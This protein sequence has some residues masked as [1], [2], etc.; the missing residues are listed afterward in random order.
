MIRKSTSNQLNE[1]I[2]QL[3]SYR[4]EQI[5]EVNLTKRNYH[6]LW[7]KNN[8]TDSFYIDDL[9]EGHKLPGNEIKLL[10]R[11]QNIDYVQTKLSEN[12]SICMRFKYKH[13]KKVDWMQIEVVPASDYSKHNVNVLMCIKNIEDSYGREYRARK[14]AEKLAKTDPLTGYLNRLAF[15]RFCS[16]C[17][18]DSAGVAFIDLNGLKQI[19][20]TEGHKAGDAYIKK[21]CNK[22]NA[23]FGEF[24]KYRIGG[25]EFVIIAPNVEFSD[26]AAAVH[27]FNISINE[28][29]ASMPICSVGH[30]WAEGKDISITELI[31]T[32]EKKMYRCKEAD[33]LRFNQD[34]RRNDRRHTT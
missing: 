4:Y 14:N 9:W 26:F 28:T 33:Y 13:L 24:K 29:A 17:N 19:N 30:S 11:L 1:A 5:I 23:A 18:C 27:H 21:C 15:D 25:D 3:I 10:R 7:S 20:D 12:L 16:S 32:A 34:R 31:A 8:S 6:V 2:L 22:M